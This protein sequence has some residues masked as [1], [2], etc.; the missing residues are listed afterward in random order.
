MKMSYSYVG[1]DIV[2]VDALEKVTGLA[3]Y[4]TDL[5]LPR[6]LHAKILKSPHPHAKIVH[7]NFDKAQSVPGVRGILTGMDTRYRFGIYI[8]DRNV[9]AVN[10]VRW[11]GEPVA[12]VAA[13]SERIAQEATDL[14][15]VEYQQLEPVLDPREALRHDAPLLHE[16]LHEFKH[17]PAF[18]PVAGT[19]IANH[20][21]IR[22]GDVKEGF[23]K[24]DV[25]VENQFFQPQVSH[26]AMEPHVCVGQYAADGTI[27]VWTSAQSPFAVR[28]LLG[29]ILGVPLHKISV[30]VPYVGGGFGGKAGI[31]IE[32]LAVL[33]SRRAGGDPVKLTLT[34]EEEFTTAPVRQGMYARIKTGVKMN[35]EIVAEEIQFIWDAGA[36]ADYAVNVGR[37]AGYSCTGPYDV[38]N[39]KCDSLTVYT[40]HQY[41]GAFRGF[42]VCELLWATER[43]MDI[44]ARKIGMDQVE[45]RLRN[46][47]RPGS[48][49]PT[50]QKLRQ[51]AGR[52]DQCIETVANQVKWG[53]KAE[54]P[55]SRKL[56][57][58]GIAS[59]WKA[60]S[61]RTDASSSAI[62]KFNEDGSVTL[63]LGLTEIGQGTTT[64]MAQI[65]AEELGVPVEK[66]H[67]KSSRDTDFSPYSWQTVA[68]RATFMDGNA[69]IAAARDA[70]DQIRTVASAILRVPKDDLSVANERV[71]LPERPDIGLPLNEL[72]NGYTFP[73]G[74][75]IGGP[76]IGRG[77][78]IARG[79]TKLDP[80]TGQGSPALKWTFGAVATEIEVD[81]DT[82]EIRIL[83]LFTAYDVGKAIN[84]LLVK[85]QVYGGAVQG[86]GV[87]LTENYVY[88][89]NGRM[90]NSNLTDYKIPRASDIP[91]EHVVDI[92]E[93]PQSDGPYGARGIAELPMLSIAPAIANAIFDAVQIDM[94][95]LP[96]S[97]ESVW[98][99]LRR[100]EET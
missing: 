43:Q 87:A 5:T 39:L 23:E 25:V 30:F 76:I 28:Y 71:F 82:G 40:N 69:V 59:L 8:S 11:V 60:P 7:I 66:I 47:L 63:I 21:K 45:F 26:V 62:I 49:T 4:T 10:K 74:N 52:V 95:D 61:M 27:R 18:N 44:V 84:P 58:K 75:A 100:K 1:R 12:A 9:L 32:P 3:K 73:N 14:I 54:N 91:E 65:A 64:A 78:Y 99:T 57:G 20:F 17:S 56:R 34:R 80:E 37:V 38:P 96:L 50:G 13:S 41:A 19:N 77:T 81:I 98:K 15:D 36:Y 42:G 89:E 93:N 83:K 79:L 22:K 97:R 16:N 51:D 86:I 53:Q 33:L 88:D 94:N 68:S 70:K 67:V 90:L 72:V 6:M 48:T 35:G 29:T 85:S 24:A 92:I 46:V 55:Q 2:R 31:N